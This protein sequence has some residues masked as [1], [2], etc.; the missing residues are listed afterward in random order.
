[1]SVI[2][3][4]RK[5]IITTK[6]MIRELE[7][8]TEGFVTK[9]E[10]AEALRDAHLQ[11]IV[12]EEERLESLT[13]KVRGMIEDGSWLE[14]DFTAPDEASAPS[15]QVTEIVTDAPDPSVHEAVA[16][17]ADE[18][19]ETVDASSEGEDWVPEEPVTDQVET[20]RGIFSPWA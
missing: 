18:P 19:P 5:D 3:D 9:V 1:M 6:N 7:G 4:H 12:L 20:K 17:I 11:K 8:L 15:T 13:M 2:E 10:D 14:V 16:A